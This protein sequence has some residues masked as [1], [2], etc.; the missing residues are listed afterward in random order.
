MEY[1]KNLNIRPNGKKVFIYTAVPWV[2]SHIEY[3]LGK[4]FRYEG[5]EVTHVIC[6]GRT[7]RICGWNVL[8]LPC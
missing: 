4:I 6:A 5:Y 2:H 7:G 1:E 3:T 8:F